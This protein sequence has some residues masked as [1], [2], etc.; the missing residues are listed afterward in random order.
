MH[1]LDPVVMS[2]QNS[3]EV[4]IRNA[5]S[6]VFVPGILLTEG[7]DTPYFFVFM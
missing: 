2:E 1:K 5:I 3:S 7:Y 6:L 4:G